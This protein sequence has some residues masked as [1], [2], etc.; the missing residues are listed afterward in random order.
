MLRVLRCPFGLVLALADVPEEMRAAVERMRDGLR[1]G[2]DM[3]AETGTEVR[4]HG[5]GNHHAYSA[6]GSPRMAAEDDEEGTFLAPKSKETGVVQPLDTGHPLWLVAWTRSSRALNSFA[7][8]LGLPFT[9]CNTAGYMRSSGW[10]GWLTAAMTVLVGCLLTLGAFLWSVVLVETIYFGMHAPATV[11]GQDVAV[12]CLLGVT[13]I[14]VVLLGLRVFTQKYGEEELLPA[15]RLLAAIH[16]LIVVV[17]AFLVWMEQPAT[18]PSQCWSLDDRPCLVEASDWATTLGWLTIALTGAVILGFAML[19]LFSDGTNWRGGGTF[20]HLGTA[21]TLG[22]AALLSHLANSGLVLLFD[23]VAAYGHSMSP[24]AAQDDHRA[25][26]LL[27]HDA[28]DLVYSGSDTLA[29]SWAPLG[30]ALV[31]SMVMVRLVRP[32]YSPTQDGKARV[33]HKVIAQPGRILFP[34]SVMTLVVL[35]TSAVAWTLVRMDSIQAA[36]STP[37]GPEGLNEAIHI[38]TLAGAHALMVFLPF[39]LLSGNVRATVAVLSDIIGY[40]R[41]AYHPLAAPPYRFDVVSKAAEA[42]A[43]LPKPVVIVG[44][45]QG[46]VLAVDIVDQLAASKCH[47]KAEYRLVTCGSPLASL[48]STYFPSEFPPER[49][50]DTAERVAAWRNLYRTTDP[51]S[52]DLGLGGAAELESNAGTA[53]LE[54]KDGRERANDP[55]LVRAH[56]DYWIEAD[57]IDAVNGLLVVEPDTA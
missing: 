6:L 3:T 56:G 48:Y 4:I 19:S 44:H 41:I 52:T 50:N 20:P 46:S 17:A 9:L 12:V 7:W 15:G 30:V 8:Y 16:C 10:S 55:T 43:K 36:S 47:I 35:V 18:D 26:P 2:K 37:E 49:R 27:R 34:L 14:W 42:I 33:V 21:I 24:W 29:A 23:R 13:L 39:A 25:I 40:W 53:D 54:T 1:T 28:G 38:L 45:S 11:F 32:L 57:Q 22:V 31:A 5:I 51:I